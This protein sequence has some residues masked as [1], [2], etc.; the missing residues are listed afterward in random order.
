M[1][2]CCGFLSRIRTFVEVV[3][4]LEFGLVGDVQLVEDDGHFPWVGAL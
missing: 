4:V 3:E 1:L 2:L